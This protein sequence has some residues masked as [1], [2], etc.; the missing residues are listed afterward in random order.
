MRQLAVNHHEEQATGNYPRLEQGTTTIK[1]STCTVSNAPTSWH[2]MFDGAVLRLT[3][4]IEVLGRHRKQASSH[5]V[6]AG[7]RISCQVYMTI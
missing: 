1:I 6:K 3:S 7:I 4:T 5:S 2:N